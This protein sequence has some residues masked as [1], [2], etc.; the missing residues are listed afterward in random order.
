ML[1]QEVSSHE[2]QILRFY[3]KRPGK[4]RNMLLG[5]KNPTKPPKQNNKPKF[6]SQIYLKAKGKRKGMCETFSYF[7]SAGAIQGK[8]IK[9]NSCV[10]KYAQAEV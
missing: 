6:R 10:H 8:E 4:V 3:R 1:T 9:Y 7:N 5:K 2:V